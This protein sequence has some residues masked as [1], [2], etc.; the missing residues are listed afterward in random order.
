MSEE[1]TKISWVRSIEFAGVL[2]ALVAGVIGLF[3]IPAWISSI[4]ESKLSNPETV[5]DFAAKI[6]PEL[7]ID[8]KG[9]VTLDRGA[10]QYIEKIEV[11]DE[12][13]LDNGLNNFERI[14]ITPI[15]FM[16]NAPLV[17]S[18]TGADIRVSAAR[19]D[20][21]NWVITFDYPSAEESLTPDIVRVEI[22]DR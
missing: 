8:A 16:Q 19:G 21:K 20:F 12:Q 17:T 11:I 9:A 5:S 6:R 4:V 7:F 3:A 14:E 18:V 22:L 10:L 15:D 13:D 2:V 1:N